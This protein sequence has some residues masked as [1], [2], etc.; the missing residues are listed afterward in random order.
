MCSKRV[1]CDHD[2]GAW[3]TVGVCVDLRSTAAHASV[4]LVNIRER[5]VEDDVLRV[6]AL[7]SLVLA[8]SIGNQ[9][10]S[11]WIGFAISACH[12]DVYIGTC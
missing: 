1:T 5:A 6:A 8:N 3:T 11:S 9:T 2:L 4:E 7:S 10:D 12:E